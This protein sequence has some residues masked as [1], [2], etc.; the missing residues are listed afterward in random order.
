MH[1]TGERVVLQCPVDARVVC[2]GQ[3]NETALE[4]VVGVPD[5]KGRAQ[6]R[7]TSPTP[8]LKRTACWIVT[9]EASL[10]TRIRPNHVRPGVMAS[11]SRMPCS[12]V[13]LFLVRTMRLPGSSKSQM[14]PSGTASA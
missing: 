10:T 8:T 2:C 6:E 3:D 11:H 9:V 12:V 4:E 5:P 14:E 1:E 13:R 7:D